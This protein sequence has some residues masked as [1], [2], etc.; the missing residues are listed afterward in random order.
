MKARSLRDTFG[1]QV[2]G[3]GQINLSTPSRMRRSP[4]GSV[5]MTPGKSIA[6]ILGAPV[7]AYLPA[8]NEREG[9]S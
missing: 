5:K 9:A 7:P 8:I 4:V 6:F 3:M 1:R 2:R